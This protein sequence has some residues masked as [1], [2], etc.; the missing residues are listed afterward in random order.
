[1][2]SVTNLIVILLLCIAGSLLICVSSSERVFV[3]HDLYDV[4]LKE[5]T[6]SILD[7][8][9]FD[10]PLLKYYWRRAMLANDPMRLAPGGPDGHHH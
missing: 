4:Q 9:G 6:R 5:N 8:H 3:S 10:Q 7:K 1:M 2:A